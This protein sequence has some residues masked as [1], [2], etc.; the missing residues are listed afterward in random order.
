MFLDSATQF[1]SYWGL[2][3]SVLVSLAVYALLGL[4][5]VTRRR[6][7]SGSLRILQWALGAILWTFYQF[8]EIAA[9]NALGNL[10]LSGADA[11]GE[12]EQ[13]QQLTAFWAPF[14]LIHLGGPDNLSAY[15]LEDN[16]FSLR[17]TV[18]M[19]LQLVGVMYAIWNYIYRGR[20]SRVLLAASAIVF[21]D[22]AA[23]YVERACALWRAN[24]DNMQE[25]EQDDYSSKK[26]A[27]PAGSSSSARVCSSSRS[28]SSSSWA[29][30]V[31]VESTIS[32]YK[33]GRALDDGEAL[34]LAQDLFHVWRR[35]L[36][37]S[38]V[39]Q[40]SPWQ[41]ASE[42]LLSLRWSSMC[43]VVEMELSLMYEVLYTKATVAHTWPGYL[44]RF[45]SPVCS[46]AAAS[47]FWLH[48]DRGH[49]RRPIGASFVGITY[50][51]LGAA[52][53][54]DVVWLL[55]AL[56]STW[57]YA[58][59]KKTNNLAPRRR[60][61]A[62]FHH[63][64]LFAG[65]WLRLHRAVVY[66]DPLRLF[67]IDPVDYRLWSGT[68]GRY[69]LLHE[70]TA[71]RRPWRR[72]LATKLGLQDNKYLSEL[73]PG[74]K[75]L[76]F[77]RVQRILPTAGDNPGPRRPPRPD[78][79]DTYTM[80]DITTCWGQEALRRGAYLFRGRGPDGQRQPILGREFEKDVL[81]WHI[82]TCIFLSRAMVRKEVANSPVHAPAIE[83]MSE[84][85]MF[86]VA[87]RRQMLP[88]LVLH[89]QLEETRRA[90]E[91]IWNDGREG[92]TTS[93]AGGGHQ[94]DEDKLAWLVRQKRKHDRS[95]LETQGS[96]RLVLDAAEVADALTK[97]SL[98]QRQ[99]APMLH[100]IFNVW[101]D[102]L[103]Y[104]AVRCSRESHAKQ[105]SSGGEL[106][107]LLWI[108]IQH[109]GPFRIGQQKPGY[110]QDSK[111]PEPKKEE[112]SKKPDEEE[113]YG[114]VD[115][116]Q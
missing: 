76:L 99:V 110:Q 81:V 26:P 85:L 25:Q 31:E 97:G 2:R 106:T 40:Q 70:C 34:L 57:T 20:R 60:P 107:T 11:S 36:V 65:W 103:L 78:G 105:L 17:K 22:G 82:A 27:E 1:W 88:G 100:L 59:L 42:K 15:A 30:A 73:P 104:A 86:L 67:G 14:L 72:W 47:L 62:W 74:V 90:L 91:E 6:S 29:A 41:R 33:E 93:A 87:E 64:A 54:L 53:A 66:L 114:L 45:T 96:R 12:E 94:D 49:G 63:Q 7:A 98:R 108:V 46:A 113:L 79:G 48:R 77:E 52:F 115:L 58:F 89:S 3:I 71:P 61:W 5:S 112:D 9:T 44:I 28:R 95:W 21:V 75:R 116:H 92:T 51:L 38:S 80:V 35:F 109:A 8:A 101:V 19:A 24:L 32:M 68:I 69:N 18:E 55:R 10:S 56:G 84:H 37:D 102:K 111:K 16:M 4:L 50:L 43:K 23:R 39:D 83:A 13:E